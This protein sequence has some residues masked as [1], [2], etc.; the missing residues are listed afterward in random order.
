MKHSALTLVFALIAFLV[1]ILPGSYHDLP[2]PAPMHVAIVLAL[3][4]ITIYHAWNA[5]WSEIH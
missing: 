3:F 4:G 2:W 1:A 5:I